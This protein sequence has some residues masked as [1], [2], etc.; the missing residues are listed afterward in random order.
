MP[1]VYDQNGNLVFQQPYPNQIYPG[2]T[3][4]VMGTPVQQNLIKREDNHFVWIQGREAAMAYPISPNT[5]LIFLDD[6]QPYVYKKKTDQEGK[7]QEFK[8]FKLVEEIPN[9]ELVQAQPESMDTSIFATKDDFNSLSKAI[10]ELKEMVNRKPSYNKNYRKG[11][12]RD[13]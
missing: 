2:L 6:Q 1:Y 12:G 11:G 8:V 7:T 3:P 5:T 13:A 10:E 4:Q 9:Q